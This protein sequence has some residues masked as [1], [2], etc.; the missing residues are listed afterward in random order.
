M[1]QLADKKK[2]SKR[3]MHELCLFFW[4]YSVNYEALSN[5]KTSAQLMSS[6]DLQ[7]HYRKQTVKTIHNSKA[8]LNKAG[9]QNTAQQY[10][11]HQGLS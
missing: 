11:I 2:E 9:A 7:E 10:A 3:E 5:S 8:S 4:P 1:R 6:Q